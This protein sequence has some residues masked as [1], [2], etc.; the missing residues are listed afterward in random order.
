MCWVAR[1]LLSSL[2]SWHCRGQVQHSRPPSTSKAPVVTFLVHE[3][4]CRCLEGTHHNIPG[5]KTT[6]HS[7]FLS[8]KRFK[9]NLTRG[10]CLSPADSLPLAVPS[11]RNWGRGAE[12]E[13]HLFKAELCPGDTLDALCSV[14]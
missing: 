3:W 8:T 4:I 1:F 14:F 7:F 11:L 12:Q 10:K 5:C 2:L 13:V 9:N 6:L